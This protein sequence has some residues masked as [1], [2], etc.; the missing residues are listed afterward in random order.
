MARY[1]TVGSL[2]ESTFGTA[3][4]GQTFVAQRAKSVGLTV[5]RQ[6]LTEENIESYIVAAAYGGALKITGTIEGNMRPKSMATFLLSVMGASAAYTTTVVSGI[7]LAGGTKY[8]LAYPQPMEFKAGESTFGGSKE[9]D[10]VG[11]GLKNLKMTF[12]AKELVTASYDYFAKNFTIGTYT[13][14][15]AA[16]YAAEDP[17]TFYTAHIY[18]GGVVVAKIKSL[19]L[20]IDRKSDDDRFV[21]GEF[22][23]AEVG[24]TG[25]TEISGTMTFTEQEYNMLQLAMTGATNNTSI[26]VN[27]PLGQMALDIFCYDLSNPA[28]VKMCVHLGNIAMKDADSTMQGQTPIDKKVSYQATGSDVIIYV[29]T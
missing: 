4:G 3:P 28:V 1:L 29:E 24:I 7:T 12:N 15:T 20:N 22:T 8:T 6:P 5:D 9:Y 10:F 16:D 14:P 2:C 26:P 23:L 25:M 19:D 18:L 11:V 13:A 17:V 21:V 27:N